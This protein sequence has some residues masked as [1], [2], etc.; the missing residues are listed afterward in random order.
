MSLVSEE[1]VKVLALCKSRPI[2]SHI[3]YCREKW[4]DQTANID[5]HDK[6]LAEA[7]FREEIFKPH[8][9]TEL[10]TNSELAKV[11]RYIYICIF[12]FFYKNIKF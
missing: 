6:R 4:A 1:Y 8:S 11:S 2:I 12:N 3:T 7:I 10:L 9:S 5:L